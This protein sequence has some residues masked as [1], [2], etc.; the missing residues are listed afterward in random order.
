MSGTSGIDDLLKEYL[1]EYD[2]RARECSPEPAATAIDFQALFAEEDAWL[3]RPRA[4]HV[5]QAVAAAAVRADT[6]L[7]A[8][9]Q[10][11]DNSDDNSDDGVHEDSDEDCDEDCDEDSVHDQDG[12]TDAGVREERACPGTSKRPSPSYR[13]S[14]QE[15][16]ERFK[17]SDKFKSQQLYLRLK[18]EQ[19]DKIKELRKNG[20]AFKNDHIAK[21]MRAKRGG[22]DCLDAL[23]YKKKIGWRK[24]SKAKNER[25]M[26]WVCQQIA[27]MDKYDKFFE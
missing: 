11:D 1:H 26:Q 2:A 27:S 9:S 12:S 3:A 22:M 15:L 4:L 8:K 7:H 23:M 17:W 19:M 24:R 5:P 14:M 6:G 10:D 20:R 13:V 21:M 18:M 25:G 16:Q